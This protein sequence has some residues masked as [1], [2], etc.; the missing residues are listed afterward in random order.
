MRSGEALA[1]AQGG[2]GDEMGQRPWSPV[3]GGSGWYY[4]VRSLNFVSKGIT[5]G[6]VMWSGFHS[7][8]PT[9]SDAEDRG[10]R[11]RVHGH[12]GQGGC[13]GGRGSDP[14]VKR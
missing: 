14:G 2:T 10:Q 7:E 12:G 6:R 3:Q 5:V 8:M 1:E 13:W 9:D 4:L 11:G